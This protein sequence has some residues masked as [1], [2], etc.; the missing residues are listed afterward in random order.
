MKHLNIIASTAL[1]TAIAQPF[2]NPAHAADSS[3]QFDLN[4]SAGENDN[5]GRAELDR[6]IVEDN[7]VSVNAGAA[8]KI[9]SGAGQQLTLR[10]FLETEQWD[11]VS[12]L[13]RLLFDWQFSAGPTAAAELLQTRL[14][15]PVDTHPLLP[16][17]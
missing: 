4:V 1:M 10:G 7:F 16:V 9:F 8:Y 2:V 17:D 5:L 3:W 14:P 6:D 15:G 13:S 12:D 11:D